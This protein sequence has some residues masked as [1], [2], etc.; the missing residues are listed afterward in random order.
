M[1]TLPASLLA[2]PGLET[3][4]ALLDRDGEEA[5]MVGGAVRNALM[6]LPVADIDIATTATPDIVMQRAA[7]AGLRALPTGI[8]HGTVTLLVDHKPFEIT[9]LRE[10]IETD[11]RH[12]IVK[13]GR[14]FSH[15]AQRR[16][17]TMNA[18]YARVDGTVEDYTDGLADLAQRRVRFIGDA[19]QRIREDYLR[20]LRLF[21]FHAAYGEGSL[22][23]DALHAAIVLRDRRSKPSRRT[24]A[25]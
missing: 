3:V 18:L 21:R 16:D 15:D 14:D 10:D 4:F 12:A 23:A 5:R 6:G 20:I 13:F 1:T 9:T 17:F 2:T 19:H 22:D 7:A 25:A 24:I 8:D 11:G